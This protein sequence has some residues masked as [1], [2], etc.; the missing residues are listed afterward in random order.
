MAD[1]Q[2]ITQN[3]LQVLQFIEKYDTSLRPPFQRFEPYAVDEQFCQEE[4]SGVRLHV[5]GRMI[6]SFE[7]Y[8]CAFYPTATKCF[9]FL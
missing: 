9:K 3:S 2:Q 4:F 6:F 7:Y 8:P 1:L 5:T